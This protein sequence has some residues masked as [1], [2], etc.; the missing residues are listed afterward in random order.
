MI[1]LDLQSIIILGLATWYLAHTITTEKCPFGFC[2][3]LRTK[4][5][6]GGLTSCIYCAVIWVAILMLVMWYSPIYPLVYAFALAGFAIGF[7]TY[8]GAGME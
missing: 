2:Q 6:L 8:T 4:L 3:W 5:P 7:R 1:T